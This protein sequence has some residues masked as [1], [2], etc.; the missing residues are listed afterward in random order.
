MDPQVR[1][2]IDARRPFADGAS[3]A[4]VGPYEVL[5][6]RVHFSIDP[7][8]QVNRGIVDLEYAPRN[9]SEQVE[10]SSDLYI[11]EPSDMARGNGRLIY[12]VNNRGNKRIVQFFNDAVH[13]NEPSTQEHAGNGFLMRRGYTIVWSGWQG[14]IIPGDGRLGIDVPIATD[15]RGEITGPVRMEFT[16]E[17]PGISSIPL[18]AND[19]TGSYE[20]ASLDSDSATF[21]LREYERHARQEIPPD[22]W[23]FATVDDTGGP[24]P[25]PMH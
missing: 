11:L 3:F 15:S 14:D 25:S 9:P 5:S 7:G 12:D 16:A 23:Q 21:T 8:D 2:R 17:E 20:T 19:Y 13:S 6:G 1:L 24:V 18:S 10:Y 22:R 4:D